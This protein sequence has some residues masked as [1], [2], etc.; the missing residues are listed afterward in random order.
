MNYIIFEDLVRRKISINHA[1]GVS[2]YFYGF[3]KFKMDKFFVSFNYFYPGDEAIG[4]K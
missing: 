4:A 3:M 2:T 1:G